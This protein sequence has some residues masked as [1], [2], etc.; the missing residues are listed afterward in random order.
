MLSQRCLRQP[1]K[2]K[3]RHN[4]KYNSKQ[5]SLFH[6]TTLGSRAPQ[7]FDVSRSILDSKPSF[8]QKAATTTPE[9][10]PRHWAL[11]IGRWPL[12]SPLSLSSHSTPR[13]LRHTLPERNLLES[14]QFP[15]ARAAGMPPLCLQVP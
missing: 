9:R 5:N 15:G 12:S 3:N 10:P 6:I 11:G 14:R 8:F 13:L 1:R 2:R 4:A 7:S